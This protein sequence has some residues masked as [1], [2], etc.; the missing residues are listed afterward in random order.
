[1][2]EWLNNRMNQ[3]DENYQRLI[4]KL[5]IFLGM[6][7]YD[8]LLGMNFVTIRDKDKTL[9]NVLKIIWIV[10]WVSQ[11]SLFFMVENTLEAKLKI[12]TLIFG[13][14]CIHTAYWCYISIC[15][16]YFI[17]KK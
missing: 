7:I 12:P 3:L 2:I 14:I 11:I 15:L 9:M 1:M 10:V 16:K 5:P 8:K 13:H 4:L 17:H 6:G